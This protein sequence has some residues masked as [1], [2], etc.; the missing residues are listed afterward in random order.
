M[1]LIQ[2]KTREPGTVSAQVF[3]EHVCRTLLSLHVQASRR[4]GGQLAFCL[5]GPGGGA[6][7][8][9]LGR[10]AVRSGREQADVTLHTTTADF[11]SLLR[12]ES[13]PQERWRCDGDAGALRRL[14]ELFHLGAGTPPA[15]LER[16]F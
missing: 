14:I 13:L 16:I 5:E 12:G 3:F 6:W 11:E 9:D 15:V 2:L 1:S 10:A 4:L 8:V 7:T